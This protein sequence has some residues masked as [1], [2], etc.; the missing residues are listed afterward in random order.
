M[1]VYCT[2]P[3]SE[4]ISALKHKM[5]AEWNEFGV[6]LGVETCTLATIAKDNK[7]ASDCMLDLVS[8]WHI[9]LSGTGSHPRTW[10]TVVKAVRDTGFGV[11]AEGLTDSHLS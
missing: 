1:Y 9:E 11:L 8:K 3:S 10:E 2:L 6:H 5:D 7:G 4:V